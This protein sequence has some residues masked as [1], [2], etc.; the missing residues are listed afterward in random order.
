MMLVGSPVA[1]LSAF[2]LALMGGHEDMAQARLRFA[3]GT[4]ADFSASRL[5]YKAQ[6]QMQV[7][8]ERGHVN[9]DFAARA[10]MVAQP[11]SILREGRLNADRLTSEEKARLKDRVFEELIPLRR[12]EAGAANA[13]LEEQR[14]FVTAIRTGR[15]PRV[16]GQIAR[17]VIAV[18]ERILASIAAHRWD[19]GSL[20]QD[21]EQAF[22]EF[23]PR[24]APE[25]RSDRG[26]DILRGPHWHRAP[27]SDPNELRRPA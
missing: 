5:S 23:S 19:D 24:C 14:D 2:G 7:W 18:A 25:L 20:K 21:N 8:S 15:E 11:G 3:N 4:V 26:A 10:A 6:R 16:T 13:L 12:M 27:A 1:D 9:L 17:E 22:S